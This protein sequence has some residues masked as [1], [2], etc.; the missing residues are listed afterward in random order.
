V[1]VIDDINND[2]VEQELEDESSSDDT[3]NFEELQDAENN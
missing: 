2:E 3:V 1:S